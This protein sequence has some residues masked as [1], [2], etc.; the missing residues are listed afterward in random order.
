MHS[1]LSSRDSFQ[2]TELRKYPPFPQVCRLN[3][4]LIPIAGFHKVNTE[5]EGEHGDQSLRAIAGQQRMFSELE[6]VIKLAVPP[7]LLKTLENA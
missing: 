7:A 2:N 5:V 4:P 3:S 1:P 6:S